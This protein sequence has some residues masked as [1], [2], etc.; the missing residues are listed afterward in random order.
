MSR[1]GRTLD[2]ERAADALARV[3]KLQ[4]EGYGNYRSYVERLPAQIVMNG[5]GQAV[6]TVCSRGANPE[7]SADAKAYR[8]LY[9]HLQYWLCRDHHA[10]PYRGAKDLIMAIVEHDQ[11]RY[12]RAHA[13]ALAYLEWL[14]KFARAFLARGGEA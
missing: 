13:E 12:V 6:A 10:A 14:K 3:R 5:L 11:D 4:D 2:Q 8:Y 9:E 1:S 7:T